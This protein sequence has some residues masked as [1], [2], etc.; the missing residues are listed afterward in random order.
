MKATVKLYRSDGSKGDKFPIKLI[1]TY[2]G[3]VRRKT[4]GHSKE[5]L[6]NEVKQLPMASHPNRDYLFDVI[7]DIEKYSEDQPFIELEDFDAAF[8]YLLGQKKKQVQFLDYGEHR[9]QVMEQE[10]RHGNARAYRTALNELRKFKDPI[11]L[12]D[13]T[14]D[15]LERFKQHKKSEGLKNTS[16]KNYL[17]ECRAIYN[18]AVKEKLVENQQPFAGLFDDL[19]IKK[20][21]ARNRYLSKEQIKLLEGLTLD[22]SYQRAVDLSLLQ[23][24]LCGADLTDLYYLKNENV[25]KDRVFLSRNKLGKKAYEFDVLL[26]DKAKAIIDKYKEKGEYV[27]PW[28]KEPQAYITFRNNHNRNLKIIQKRL[29]LELHP[30]NDHLTTK[31]MRHTFAT[32]GKFDRIEE[33]ILRELMGHERNEIDTAYKDR[34]PEEDRDAAH[35]KI[36]G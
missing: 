17:V 15:L 5:Q 30:K 6:W 25:T 10:G 24:Y 4:I 3:K 23:F 20:R 36:I 28:R 33:D 12:K 1:L 19:T 31:V 21:R 26:S 7:K 8:T 27:F 22:K 32:L 16:I 11:P 34:Y 29:Q 9:A 13:V 18:W 35:L 2:K 14:S